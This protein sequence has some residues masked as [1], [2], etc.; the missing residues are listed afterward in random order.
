MQIVKTALS[1]FVLFSSLASADKK[2][3]WFLHS[4]ISPDGKSIAFSYK[5]DVY[6]VPAEGGTARALTL[7]QDWDGHPI[8]SKDGR[9]IAFASDRAGNL[10]V[11]I[12][13]SSG[14]RAKRLT[15]H[16]SNDF[17]Q[18]FSVN[19]DEVLFKSA[20]T[21]SVESSVFPTI[22]LSETYTV[23]TS[24]G[25]PQMISTIP[26]SELRYSP[27]GKKLLYRDEKSYESEFRKH[28]VSAFARDVWLQDLETGKH[29]Q[30]TNFA[31]GDHN[32]VWKDEHSFYYT[33]ENKSGVFNVW[34][35]N[36]D[37]SDRKQITKFKQHPVRSLSI[38]DNGTLAFVHHGSIYTQ[39]GRSLKHVDINIANDVHDE[40]S[41]PLS[42]SAPI[43][44]YAVSPN[45]KE[46]AFIVRGEVFV[47]ST[48]F[49]N[50]RLITNTPERERSVSFDNDGRTLLYASER[51]GSWGLYET[52]IIDDNEPYF[53]AATTLTEKVVHKVESDSFQPAYSPDG[54]KIAF[55]SG[56]DE[57]QV[58]N[59]ETKE[60][61]VALG[62]QHNYS[63]SDGDIIFS[64]APDSY[65]MS[66]DFAPRN[67]L[68]INN[69]GVFPSDGSQPPKDVSLSGY[70]DYGPS[71]NSEGNTVIWTSTRF[72]MR[73]H[74]SW[75]R[76]ADVMAVFLTQDSYDKFHLS[77]EE[78]ELEQELNN[79][80]SEQGSEESADKSDV[81]SQEMSS[82]ILKIEWDNIEN[83]IERLT[84]HASDLGDA[85]LTKDNQELYYLAKFESGYDL[86]RHKIKDG[87][88]ELVVKLDAG[89]ASMSFS[90]K[91]KKLYVLAD[92]QLQQG[93]IGDDVSLEL[94]QTDPVMKLS[95]AD[96]RNYMFEHYWRI[97]KDKFYRD[98]FH[99]IDWDEMKALY[100]SKV[101]SI[102]YSR[103]L[104]DLFSEMTGELNASHIDSYYAPDIKDTDDST[105]SSGLFLEQSDV[106][107]GLLVTEVIA[108]GPFDY[109]ESKVKA[110]VTLV[111]VNGV[112]LNSKQN[113]NQLMN[114]TTDKRVRFRFVDED[115]ASFEEV[116]KPISPDELSDLLYSRWVTS[117]E[118]LV[119][120]LSEGKLGYVH[121]RSMD[122]PS[123]RNVY[124][125]LLGKYH[126]KQAVVVDTRFNGGG[127]L[128]NDLAKLFSGSEYT[129]MTVRGREYRG[130]PQ[131]QWNKPS[132][133]VI[134]EGNYSD[135]SGFSY[136]YDELGIGK[137]VGMPVPGT[138]T[139]VWWESSISGDI[140]S[141]VPQV[142][143]K[144]TKG[145]YME[146]NQFEPDYQIK[147][148]PESVEKRSR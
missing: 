104:A 72:G 95:V 5:G 32:P 87:S 11:Y 142:G 139:A 43:T 47:A 115:G 116:I 88:T 114:H 103:D 91:Q 145:E 102:G 7:H 85:F 118:A 101:A 22:R 70:I 94:I 56:R 90:E 112:E 128:H 62:K 15:Y 69:I 135:A 76:K 86:W 107:E 41:L 34:Q 59:R 67:R 61:N 52:S 99:G 106:S 68:F 37:G 131:D 146:N 4:S 148:D 48:E 83:R 134:N 93:D 26:A 113:L 12:M 63:Y 127:W 30:I 27:S 49:N 57:I 120:Q 42:L 126:D 58:L 35:S 71:W 129:T 108:K 92:G 123:F 21:D 111:A 117:R 23:K 140:E 6:V 13:P 40:E 50:T 18:D 54:K 10:D 143:V 105:G 132:I 1:L 121:V 14:G 33:S 60:V 55:L 78:Y 98:D 124:S 66:A 9:Q 125:N 19:N 24:G 74:G 138:M 16:S 147:N 82:Q 51:D 17:P 65:W 3:E 31:G 38:S 109:A 53:F 44:E 46:V 20:R 136:T 80:A 89:S 73:D 79:K 75:G 2:D 84:L 45:G 133:L 122:D 119:E 39:K 77:K 141:G 29:T 36:L 96:E 81:T 25:T 144:N 28:D 130:A 100:Q 97:V 137:T 110:G 8:W 64:W